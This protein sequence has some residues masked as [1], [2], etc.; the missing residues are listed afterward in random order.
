[1]KTSPFISLWQFIIT[2]RLTIIST[3]SNEGCRY[4]SKTTVSH[5][6]AKCF[7]TLTIIRLHRWRFGR[8]WHT[9]WHKPVILCTAKRCYVRKCQLT[10]VCLFEHDKLVECSEQMEVKC[11]VHTG[12]WFLENSWNSVIAFSSAGKSLNLD[13]IPGKS[14]ELN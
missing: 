9:N 11:R 12:P 13:A 3:G 2:S 4:L 8:L 1:M 7:R 14:L 5:I 6:F 10:S